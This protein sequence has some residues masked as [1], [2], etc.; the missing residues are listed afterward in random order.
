MKGYDITGTWQS[1][2]HSTTINWDYTISHTFT[3]KKKSGTVL[4]SGFCGETGT[5]TV[6]GK[7]VNFTITWS[8]GNAGVF[9][10]TFIDKD[11]MSGTF[12]ETLSTNTGTWTATRGGTAVNNPDRK[13]PMAQCGAGR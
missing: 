13:S 11:T 10:G 8:S 1:N 9:T 7:N 3:G 6:D 5:Y 2:V 12:H 4:E